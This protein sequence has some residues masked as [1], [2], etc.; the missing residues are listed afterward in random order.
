MDFSKLKL[1]VYDLL[2]VILPGLLGIFGVWVLLK[3]WMPFV[4][5]LHQLNGT[6][7][8]V[9]LIVA[10]GAGN[11]LQELGD[12][13]VKTLKGKRFSRKSRDD[14]WS[15]DEALPVRAAITSELGQELIFVDTA[16]DYCLTRLKDRFA[17]RDMFLA[18]SDLCR[19]L[20]LLAFLAFVPATR[21]AWEHFSPTCRYFAVILGFVLFMFSV[22]WLSWKRMVRFRELSEGTV[23]RAYLAMVGEHS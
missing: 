18:T 2:G 6:E 13:A 5:S 22:A 14:F 16:F 10:F 19:S 1:E 4:A 20:W 9:L 3:G 7:L 8:T 15:S 17:K 11:L 21:I 23:F 12:S